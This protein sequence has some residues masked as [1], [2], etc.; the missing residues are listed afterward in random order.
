MNIA[1]QNWSELRSTHT[2]IQWPEIQKFMHFSWFKKEALLLNSERQL[3]IYGSSAYIIPKNKIYLRFKIK[4]QF[5][6]ISKEKLKIGDIVCDI[7]DHCTGKLVKIDIK[8]VIIANRKIVAI[9]LRK[10]IK[11]LVLDD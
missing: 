2:V 10:N 6:K 1:P 3:T 11:K 7:T 5:Y 8:K 9:C 4:N